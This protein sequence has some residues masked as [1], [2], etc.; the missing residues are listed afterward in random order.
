MAKSPIRQRTSDTPIKEWVL[1]VSTA[2][3]LQ[4]RSRIVTF[5][6]WAYGGSLATTFVVFVLQGF[7]HATGFQLD[8]ES[9]RWLGGATIGEIAGLLTIT[10]SHFFPSKRR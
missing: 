10:V 1:E 8:R 2:T 7:S 6:L 3:D 9:L 4:M 5:L